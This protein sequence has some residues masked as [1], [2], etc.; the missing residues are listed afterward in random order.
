MTAILAGVRIVDL[1]TNHAAGLAAMLLAEVGAEV[2]RIEPPSGDPERGTPNFAVIHRSKGSL[3]LDL[4]SPDGS[5]EL[6][7]LLAAADVL[8]HDRMPGDLDG[9]FDNAN[10]A[11]Q[12]PDLIS[13][14]IGSWPTGHPL[15]GTPVD[16]ALAMAQAGFCDEQRSA[17]REGPVYLRFLLGEGGAAYL[18][19]A[20]IVARL[21]ARDKTGRGG[22]ADTSLVQ[23]ALTSVIMFWHRAERETQSLRDG[24]NKN[25]PYFTFQCS[26]GEWLH[27]MSSPDHA[28]K[29]KEGLDALDP[30][31][32]AEAVAQKSFPVLPSWGANE[33]VFRTRPRQEWLDELWAHDVSV[34]PCLS[35]GEAYFDEQARANGYV[36]AIDDPVLGRTLQPGSPLQVNPPAQVRN[37]APVIDDARAVVAR[38][39]PRPLR[40]AAGTTLRMPL[41][42]VKVLDLGNFLAGPFAPMIMAMMGAEVIKLEAAS[43][44]QMRWVEWSFTACQRGKRAIAVDLKNPAGRKVLERLVKWADIVHHNL[45]MP[46]ARKLGLDYETLRAINPRIVY[47]HVSSYGP[48][49]PRK[50]WPGYDQLFQAACGWEYESAG[51]GNPPIWNRFGMM[52]HQCAMASLV[53][54]LLALHHRDRTGEGSAVAASL[55]GA[56]LLTLRETVVLP[57]G[58]IAPYPQLDGD[59]MGLS[60]QRRLFCCADGWIMTVTESA[61]AYDRLLE[62]AGVDDI[63]GLERHFIQTSV[64][65][66]LAEVAAAGGAAVEAMRDQ[67]LPFLDNPANRA[68]RLVATYP[69]RI[70]GQFDQV[71]AFLDFHDMDVKLDRAPPVTGEHSRELLAEFGFTPTEIA[72][73]L[74]CGLVVAPSEQENLA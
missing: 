56:G 62:I 13:S 59:Q 53:A 73:M 36:V 43:G 48:T 46:A 35:M 64:A 11:A 45:R 44:D 68:A 74:D 26:D 19:A 12:F 50:D 18:S 31:V 40:A 38:W 52:D 24:R 65:V 37:P 69:H 39:A 9:F 49:G 8:I 33:I 7:R 22:A 6:T 15:A 71:G 30:H 60:P 14:H 29:M 5:G 25:I 57:D 42:G 1:S 21:I 51:P 41:E 32:R 61:G 10:L 34:Q 2:V 4:K 54:T 3:V 58:S 23:G 28:P 63:A 27:V 66:A 72:E 17:Q 20:G 70:Y 55:L 67:R 47:A 16:E